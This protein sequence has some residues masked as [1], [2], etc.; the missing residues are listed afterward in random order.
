MD[1]YF[2]VL[3]A[4][5]AYRGNPHAVH[6]DKSNRRCL[7]ANLAVFYTF[8]LFNP[9]FRYISVIEII[10]I[11]KGIFWDRSG[12][13]EV[14]FE[15]E[16]LEAGNVCRKPWMKAGHDESV[17]VNTATTVVIAEKLVCSS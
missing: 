3:I 2:C 5:F 17:H 9:H 12:T 11:W 16:S 4:L 1:S 7:Q 6:A 15:M 14:N 8:Y 10:G 13:Y